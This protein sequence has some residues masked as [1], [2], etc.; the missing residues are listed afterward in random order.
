MFADKEEEESSGERK[1]VVTLQLDHLSFLSKHAS[2]Q[3]TTF[4]SHNPPLRK[5][6]PPVNPPILASQPISAL[7]PSTL[8]LKVVIQ[9]IIQPFT[10]I[11]GRGGSDR[12]IRTIA[13]IIY[14]NMTKCFVSRTRFIC[15][16]GWRGQSSR[17][18]TTGGEKTKKRYIYC[19]DSVQLT[20]GSESCYLNMLLKYMK[21]PQIQHTQTFQFKYINR[22]F[23]HTVFTLVS[24]IIKN[25]LADHFLDK[26]NLLI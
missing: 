22:W 10:M 26:L 17:T 1:K 2:H 18:T 16:G 9:M 3:R 13:Q 6:G 19:P 7:K 20:T 24:Q 23:I 14:G 25:S 8:L 21:E 15:G 12:H 11:K 5:R 4:T